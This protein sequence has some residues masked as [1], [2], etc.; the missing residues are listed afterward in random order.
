MIRMTWDRARW[1]FMTG[2]T[3]LLLIAA[4][5]GVMIVQIDSANR[6][7]L[8]AFDIQMSLEDVESALSAAGRARVIYMSDK[9]PQVLVEAQSRIAEA[10]SRMRQILYQT[11]DIGAHQAYYTD[12]ATLVDRRLDILRQSIADVQAG[13][14]DLLSQS[15]YTK[16]IAVVGDRINAETQQMEQHEEVFA[17]QS[18]IVSERLF[19]AII[20][21]LAGAFLFSI[22]LLYTEYRF[23]RTELSERRRAEQSALDSQE[24]LRLLSVRLIRA[25]DEQSRKFSRELH[26]SL[27]QYLSLVKMNLSRFLRQAPPSELLSECME[28]LDHSIAE[29]RTISYLLHPPM[30]DDMGFQFAAK[31]CLEGFSQRSGIR[32]DASIPEDSDRLPLPVEITLFRVLQESLTNIHRHSESKQAD[33]SLAMSPNDV[34][35]RIRDYG[36]GISPDLLRRFFATGAHVGVGLAGMRERVREQGGHLDIES[37]GQGTTVI[38]RI[39]AAAIARAAA[40]TTVAVSSA[41]T[42]A[43]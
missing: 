36:K 21:V 27:G 35:M 18:R 32:V 26:D 43:D 13:K 9:D 24:A 15:D 6:R 4:V 3:L 23:L 8:H 33:V 1:A 20:S 28:L 7:V 12:L 16:Q 42:V 40:S 19:A 14:N 5:A 39:P 41:S 2:V 37:K 10:Q 31:W 38:V 17:N 30:L 22:A 25:Q 34:T 29:S 11:E